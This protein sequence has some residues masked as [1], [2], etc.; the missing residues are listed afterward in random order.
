MKKCP[1]C[2]ED[3]QD[4]AIVC[5]H[6]R[7][8]LAA[9]PTPATAAPSITPASNQKRIRARHWIAAAIGGWIVLVLISRL[10]GLSDAAS[11][12]P[13]S[14]PSADDL[15]ARYTANEVEADRVFKGHRIMVNG[16]VRDIGKELLGRAYVT[17][18]IQ[19]NHFSTVQ[20]IFRSENDV[21]RVSKGDLLTVV[22]TIEGK[23]LGNVLG[24]DCVKQ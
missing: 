24:S 5:K 1:F 19:G 18:D 20:A 12:E 4:A 9:Q 22:C 14:G 2:A 3:I 13:L 17:F 23:T 6:C 16:Q 11:S 7:R 21:T 15:F 10:L 8:E